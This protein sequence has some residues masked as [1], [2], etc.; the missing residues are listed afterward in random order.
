LTNLRVIQEDYIPLIRD[1]RNQILIDDVQ[2]VVAK[3][4]TYIQNLLGYGTIIVQSAAQSRIYFAGADS[5]PSNPDPLTGRKQR[6]SVF[7][8]KLQDEIDRRR[9]ERDPRS[10]RSLVEKHVYG[11]APPPAVPPVSVPAGH[12]GNW[13]FPENPEIRTDKDR[14]IIWRKFWLFE[15][16]QLLGPLLG[17]LVLA[18]A[19]FLLYRN[20]TV[21]AG[22]LLASGLIVGLGLLFWAWYIVTDYR[23]D[24]YV[25]TLSNLIDIEKKPLGPENR[26]SAGLGQIQNV[27]YQTT[28]WGNLLGYGDVFIQTAGTNATFTFLHV[29]RPREV[30]T[31]INDYLN[32]FREGDKERSLRE[33]LALLK[34][35]HSAQLDKGE[36]RD[37]RGPARGNAPLSGS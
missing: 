33:S 19:L 9:K 28:F 7:R 29:P 17:L 24:L 25:L 14:T 27:N 37:P 26:R 8:K 10:V 1:F 4:D 34:E 5:F 13:I 30:A 2:S 16:I 23:N 6:N 35:Y 21:A 15:A 3:T 12:K 31:T 11:T 36:L 18:T 22:T 32:S 20:T